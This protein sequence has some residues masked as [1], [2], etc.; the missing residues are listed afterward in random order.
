MKRVAFHNLGC[1]VNSY[2]AQS[3]EEIMINDGYEVVSFDEIA[4]VYVVNTCVVTATADKKS[5]Q[6]LRR[7]R[8]LNKDALIVACGCYV[9]KDA[10]KLIEE[11]LCD[12]LIGNNEKGKIATLIKEHKNAVS[13]IRCEGTQYE[14][15]PYGVCEERSRAFIKIQ[16]GCDMFCSY[17]IIPSVR[18]KSRSRLSED[19]ID[20]A[21]RLSR[22]GYKEVVITGIH[23]SS[24][25]SPDKKR[26]SDIFKMLCEIEGIERIRFG[27]VEPAV[28]TEDLMRVLSSS[29]KFCKH[30]HLSLQSCSDKVLSDMNRHY[31]T[32]MIYRSVDRIRNVWPY[33]GISA[34]II[35]GFPGETEKEHNETMKVL[36]DIALSDVH[37]FPFS[38]REGTRAYDM[39]GSLTKKIKEKRT[40]E[41]INLV[42]NT[43]LKYR[44]SLVGKEMSVLFE[45]EASGFSGEYVRVISKDTQK[46][47]TI[48]R[49]RAKEI[50]KQGRLYI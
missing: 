2:E 6:M 19:I 24:F 13:D 3:M 45:D 5:R 27:S 42:E 12:L 41:I 15:I 7:A 32:D 49:A 34:D 16:D 26:L 8:T 10:D 11:K 50:D 17:C 4:D 46:I 40:G 1:K 23:I 9:Q 30:V 29:E 38:P 44:K 36:S 21:K 43:G 48:V 35:A 14:D 33:A 22:K 47:G 39:K 28:I 37:A 20:E 31:R 18:G 25:L